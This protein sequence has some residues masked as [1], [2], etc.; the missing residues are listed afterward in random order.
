VPEQE[1]PVIQEKE[2]EQVKVEKAEESGKIEQVVEELK[3]DQVKVSKEKVPLDQG[4]RK[5]KT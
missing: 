3:F 5:S 4:F 2:A 1:P